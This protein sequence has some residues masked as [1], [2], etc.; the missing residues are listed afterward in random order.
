MRQ[1]RQF[2]SVEQAVPSE[3]QHTKPCDDCPFGRV[4]LRGWLADETPEG[5]IQMAH[6]ETQINCHTLIG[7]QCAGAAIYRAN[8]CK[9][10]RN[11]SLLRLKPDTKR[12]FATPLEFLEHHRQR[13]K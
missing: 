8:V 9:T 7:P 11:P 13:G 4:A 3:V 10:P 5:W 2:I 6:G 12:V 1:L